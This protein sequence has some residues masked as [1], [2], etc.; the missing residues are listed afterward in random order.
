MSEHQNIERNMIRCAAKIRNMESQLNHQKHIL[1]DNPSKPITS[2][3]NQKP[4]NIMATPLSAYLA[5]E[6]KPTILKNP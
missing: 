5:E 1:G 6:T 3:K 2:L 4:V